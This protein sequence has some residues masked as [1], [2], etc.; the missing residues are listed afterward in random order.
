MVLHRVVLDRGDGIIYK[1][2]NETASHIALL[3][4][5]GT[6]VL[7]Q[8]CSEDVSHRVALDGHDGCN[9]AVCRVGI[10]QTTLL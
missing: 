2:T 8:Q 3:C 4:N 6:D 1:G 7:Y 5:D 10:C 9:I